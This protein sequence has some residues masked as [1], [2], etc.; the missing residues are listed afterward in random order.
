MH[1]HT[2]TYMRT[3]ACE[4]ESTH[5]HKHV[6]S[7]THTH[8]KSP[9]TLCQ[10][11]VLPRCAGRVVHSWQSTPAHPRPHASTNIHHIHSIKLLSYR[12]VQAG[13]CTPGKAHL[14]THI[15]R[16]AHKVTTYTPPNFRP[17]AVCKRGR[18]LQAKHT[19]TPT[20]TN[21][22][23]MRSAKL[24]SYRSVQAG[25][26]TPGKAHLH[27]H[28]HKHPH[29]CTQI[30]H[31]HSAKLSSY[32]SVQAGSCTP[33]KAHLHTHIHRNAH[34]VTTYNAAVAASPTTCLKTI[35]RSPCALKVYQK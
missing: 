9:H 23:H 7:F 11:F 29:A 19:C 35:T 2:H 34:K 4:A 25:S 14:R 31:I 16:N 24:S 22:H 28:K 1:K 15:Y 6:C 8:T 27:T 10:T 5:V 20:S 26:C 3:N 33:G 21:I 32:R 30:H 17:T 12:S 13:S 18:A